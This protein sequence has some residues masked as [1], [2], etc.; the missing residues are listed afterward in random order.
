MCVRVNETRSRMGDRFLTDCGSDTARLRVAARKRRIGSETAGCGSDTRQAGRLWYGVPMIV[1]LAGR[2]ALVTGSARG[3]G[4]AIAKQLA[5]VG[6]KVM[7]NDIDEG[8]AGKALAAM[9]ASGATAEACCGDLTAPDFPQKLVDA[10][11]EAHG[12]IDIIVNNAGY[13]WDNVIQKTQDDQFQ[14][15]L[16]IHLVTPFRVLRAASG[17]IR[18]KAK[19]EAAAGIRVQRKVVNISSISGTYGN[20]GQAGYASGKAGVVGLTRTLAK[21][22]G[23][24]HV[25]VNAV[26]YGFIETRLFQDLEAEDSEIEMHGHKIRIG[27]QQKTID[28]VK[29]IV[30]LGRTGTVEE[31]AG[32]VLFLCSALA[33]YMTGECLIVSGGARF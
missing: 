9:R 28:A 27:V 3:I 24:Y 20:A 6:A 30:P 25:N 16:D 19:A 15:M 23:R 12:G 14:A 17:W 13:T 4:F 10:T 11:I 33:D 1:T 29:Y 7:L 26:A 21:E 5:G 31:A 8:A 18:E 22:W 32:P 2:T